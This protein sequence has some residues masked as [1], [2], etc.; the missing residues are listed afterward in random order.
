[1]DGTAAE[2]VVVEKQHG[3]LCCLGVTEGDETI[4]L[5]HTH[6]SRTSRNNRKCSTFENVAVAE[7]E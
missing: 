4:A 2:G 7:V 6:I 1:V 5:Q 3:L